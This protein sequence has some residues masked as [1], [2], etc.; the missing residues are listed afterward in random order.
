MAAALN[1]KLEGLAASTGAAVIYVI[2]RDGNTLAASNW[3]MPDSFVGN[4]YRF[5]RY[6]A[7][8]AR[9]G[10]AEQFALGTVSHRPGLYLSRRTRDGGVVVVKLELDRVEREWRQAGG[11]TFA[12][13]PQ[14]V[15]LVTSRGSWRFAETRPL[16][17][18]AAAAARADFGIAALGPRPWRDADGRLTDGAS[19]ETLMM[20]TSPADA[21]GWRV[22]LAM[23]TRGAI[24]AAMR[25]AAG[26]AA[27]AMLAL[28]AMGWALRE[29]ARRR[30]ERTEAL[31]AA[32]AERTADLSARSPN[33]PRRRRAP[34]TCA[35][36]CARRTASPRWARSPPASRMNRAAGRGDP[37]LCRR[38][39]GAAGSRCAGGGARQPARHRAG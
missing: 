38:G 31:E 22:T 36:G 10:Q 39:R 29:R 35:R 23:P 37:Y 19:G 28:V 5:R 26:A 2:D 6:Y 16:A 3:R 9:T 8:A 15:I 34:T 27:L 7:Q 1:R 14:G 17:P 25:N 18:A 4:N 20:A 33:A 21:A 24:T 30:A 11:I 13:G 32:V 12:T